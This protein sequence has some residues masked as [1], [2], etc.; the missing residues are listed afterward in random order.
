LLAGDSI[1]VSVTPDPEPLDAVR[2][3]MPQ[4]AVMLAYAHGPQLADALEMK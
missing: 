4:C 1:I 3:V 2:H